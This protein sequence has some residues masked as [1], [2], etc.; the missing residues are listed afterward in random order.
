MTTGVYKTTEDSSFDVSLHID[1]H[2]IG[3]SDYSRRPT[4]FS[5]FQ[6]SIYIGYSD[7]DPEELEGFLVPLEFLDLEY[8]DYD[9]FS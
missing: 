2:E 7:E 9:P 3:V 5:G 8:E 4:P 1:G 6:K